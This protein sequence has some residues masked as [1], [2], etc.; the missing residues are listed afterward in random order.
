MLDLNSD[1]EASV[2]RARPK[3]SGNRSKAK[4]EKGESDSKDTADAHGLG[5]PPWSSLTKNELDM[6]D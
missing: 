3:R 2:K 4:K 1:V 5:I 6:M